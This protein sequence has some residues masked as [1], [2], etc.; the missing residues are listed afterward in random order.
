LLPWE[1]EHQVHA[2]IDTVVEA[3]LL[4]IPE[5]SKLLK[6]IGTHGR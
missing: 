1:L 6:Q 4:H 5:R 2:G 3:V